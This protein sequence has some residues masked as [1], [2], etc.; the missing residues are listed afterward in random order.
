MMNLKIS[1]MACSSLGMMSARLWRTLINVGDGDRL[2]I[3]VG[4]G[5]VP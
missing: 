4:T 1:G 3:G 5:G 2:L